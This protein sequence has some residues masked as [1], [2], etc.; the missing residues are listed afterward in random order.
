MKKT[1]FLLKTDGVM[2]QVS[3]KNQHT[4]FTL[5][6]LYDLI[7]NGCDMV[8]RIVLPNKREMW[9]DEEGKLRKTVPPVNRI[10]TVLLSDAGGIP[11]DYVVGN[12]V[13]L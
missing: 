1:G 2:T 4:G 5:Q 3:A 9:L 7:G 8:Q 10:A 12:V 6:E 13:I 11:G